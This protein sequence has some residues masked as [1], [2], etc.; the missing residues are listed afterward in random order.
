MFLAGIAIEDK[1][2]LPLASRLRDPGLDASAERLE[3]AYDAETLVL[4]LDIR[5]RDEIL[6][7]LVHCP[8]DSA[9]SAPCS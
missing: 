5:E 7:V 4:A 9:S 8:R 1:L 3:A 6:Q 2:V